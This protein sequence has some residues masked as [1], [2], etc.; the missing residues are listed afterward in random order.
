MCWRSFALFGTE[1]HFERVIHWTRPTTKHENA[2]L[3]FGW[4]ENTAGE[5]VSGSVP[6]HFVWS[7]AMRIS[8]NRVMMNIMIGRMFQLHVHPLEDVIRPA[9]PLDTTSFWTPRVCG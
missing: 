4:L 1:G 6:L 2:S 3:G 7:M 5:V 8:V 9:H